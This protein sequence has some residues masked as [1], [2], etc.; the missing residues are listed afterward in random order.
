[1]APYVAA[2]HYQ[3]FFNF[4]L[5]LDVDGAD[6]NVVTEVNVKAAPADD[7]NPLRNAFLMGETLLRNEK[8]AQRSLDLAS[9][10]RWGVFNPS[11]TNTLAQPA[12]YL[13]VPGDNSVPYLGED[14][15]VRR[16]AGFIND[17][18]WATPFNPAEM[19]AAGEYPNQS[20]P[21]EGL[22]KWTATNRSLDRQDVV[23]WYTFAPTHIPRPEEWPVMSATKV[24]FKLVPVGFFSKN[25]ALDVPRP[26]R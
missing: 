4:R 15:P 9:S 8:D 19:H 5:D 10:R 11:A 1:M 20:E 3:H 22:P 23:V 18:F 12:G 26:R 2:P 24:G 6:G 21:G 25:P 7:T 17:H 16:R 14:S 13:L